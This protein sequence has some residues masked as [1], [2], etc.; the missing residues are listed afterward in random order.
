VSRSTRRTQTPVLATAEKRPLLVWVVYGLGIL[1][2]AVF[3]LSALL[4]AGTY[5]RSDDVPVELGVS[6]LAL[7][8][9]GGLIALA[10]GTWFW[11][12]RT[13]RS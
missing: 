6:T 5:F 7:V 8:V 3:V 2:A 9:W 12:R 10:V 11:R 4:T 13:G 1:A